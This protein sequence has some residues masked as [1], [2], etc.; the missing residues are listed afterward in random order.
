MQVNCNNNGISLV[1]ACSGASLIQR[2]HLA[3]DYVM[4]YVSR[5]TTLHCVQMCI[6]DIEADCIAFC[7]DV[8]A[9][10]AEDPKLWQHRPLSSELQ[11]YAAADVSQLLAVADRLS[12]MLGT[13][14]Q[15]VVRVLSQ[16]SCQLKLPV[17]PGT[18]V[19]HVSCAFSNLFSLL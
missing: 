4:L 12:A 16:A 2:Y 19:T 18:Q 3:I 13:V 11:Q 9:K 1:H 7:T 6:V 5:L 10:M 14:G 17:M 8:R 15:E